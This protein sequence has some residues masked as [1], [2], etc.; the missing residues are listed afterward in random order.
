MPV[1]QLNRSLIEENVHLKAQDAAAKLAYRQQYSEPI[2]ND[3]FSWVHDQ[4]QRVDLLPSN[5]LSKGLYT[6][7][8]RQ[9]EL[10]VFPPCARWIPTIW[11]VLCGLFPWDGRMTCFVGPSW[12]LGNWDSSRALWPP[13]AYRDV[14]GRAASGTGRG[15]KACNPAIM[16][17]TIG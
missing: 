11:S 17:S 7:S 1:A 9:T 12:V 10:K 4:R 13:A 8:E 3:F 14:G 15:D 16:I 2:A 6:I 5:P